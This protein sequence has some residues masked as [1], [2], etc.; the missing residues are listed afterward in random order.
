MKFR[1]LAA[2]AAALIMTTTPVLAAD[3]SRTAA[4]VSGASQLGGDGEGTLV[5]IIALV[6]AAIAA[7][8][9][10]RNKD[11]TPDSP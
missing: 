3:V 11:D 2:A 9:L 5:A 8:L 7:Y 1:N 6:L 10:A 4:P